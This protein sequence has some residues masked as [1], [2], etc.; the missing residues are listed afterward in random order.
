MTSRHNGT[1]HVEGTLAVTVI[2][3]DLTF[4]RQPLSL[5][6][7]RSLKLT[8]TER[9]MDQLVNGVMADGLKLAIYPDATGTRSG[10]HEYERQSVQPPAVAAAGGGDHRRPGG[11]GKAVAER[12][13]G[14]G[15]SR[16]ARVGAAGERAGK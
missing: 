7:Y 16:R 5:G 12:A 4:V 11:R 1:E 3:G 14:D 8:G 13:R 10:V 2:N 15:P 9:V 6:H